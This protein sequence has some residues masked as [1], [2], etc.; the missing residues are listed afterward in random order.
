[1]PH[2]ALHLPLPLCRHSES[3]HG[4]EQSIT[5]QV[6]SGPSSSPCIKAGQS[7]PAWRIGSQ[8]Q[9]STRDRSWSPCWEPYRETKPHNCHTH[10][11]SLGPS[12]P[13]SLIVGSEFMNSSVFRSAVSVDSP[14]PTMTHTIPPPFLQQDSRSSTQCLAADLCICF[15]Q[16]LDRVSLETIRIVTNLLTVDGQYRHPL[17]Y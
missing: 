6:E 1:M 5:H 16:L 3:A 11:E 12:H 17:H 14:Y 7:N 13:G 15:Y 4:L 10:A 2:P 8:R 9:V